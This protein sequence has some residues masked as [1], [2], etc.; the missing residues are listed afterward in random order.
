M[1]KV[2]FRSLKLKNSLVVLSV[3]SVCICAFALY[4][5]AYPDARLT[6]STSININVVQLDNNVHVSS[7]EV[8]FKS[9]SQSSD[10]TQQHSRGF[11]IAGSYFE[12]QLGAAMNMLTLSKW[13]KS[14]GASPV[15][16]YVR[17]SLFYFPGSFEPKRSTL[18]FRDYFDIDYW[19]EKCLE[20][21]AMPLVS[22][23]TFMA[24]KPKHLILVRIVGGK[25]IILPKLAYVN[26]EIINEPVCNRSINAL[27]GMSKEHAVKELGMEIVRDVCMSFNKHKALHVH[28]FN[29]IIYGQ[30]DPANTVVW[31]KTWEGIYEMIRIKIIEQE[32]HRNSEA[33]DMLRTSRRIIDDS[34]KYVKNILKSSFG[35]YIGISF[36][37]IKRSKAFYVDHLKGQM[38]FFH[39]CI[40]RLQRTVSLLNNNSS[41]V[42][43]ALDLGKFGDIKAGKYLTKKMMTDIEN[44]LFQALYNDTLTMGKWEHTFVDITNGITDSGYIATLQS[45]ILENSG[46]LVMFGGDS[47]FQ[48]FLLSDFQKKHSNPCFREVCYI[49]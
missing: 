40:Q 44:E 39:S 3:V 15:E 8:D 43:L 41:S 37:S 34:K 11:I 7:R 16:P 27:E 49:Y 30:Y 4:H 12:Q 24:Q 33:F 23:D 26:D 20:H 45:T 5:F 17:E 48:R 29:K 1:N 18:R 36:R 31:F 35:S 10:A 19:N 25:N 14:V 32:F 2:L 47:N 28:T 38:E 46:C 21:N 42:F 9:D 6:A 22:V 13:A